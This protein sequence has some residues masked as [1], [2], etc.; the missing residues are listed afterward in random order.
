[1]KGLGIVHC[2]LIKR[3]LRILMLA[4]VFVAGISFYSDNV[5]LATSVEEVKVTVYSDGHIP[6]GVCQRMEK[7]VQ[8]IGTQLLEG[9]SL[10]N[11]QSQKTHYEELIRQ[12]FDKVLV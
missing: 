9:K 11:V 7:S 1:M 12:V 10:E 5:L 8:A 3:S 6:Q 4:I 2:N